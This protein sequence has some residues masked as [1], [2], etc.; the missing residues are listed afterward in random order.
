MN[1]SQRIR[2]MVDRHSLSSR[3]VLDRVWTD[4]VRRDVALARM[5]SKYNAATRKVRATVAGTNADA[6]VRGVTT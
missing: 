4:I 2:R 1:L 5:E 3:R 6:E